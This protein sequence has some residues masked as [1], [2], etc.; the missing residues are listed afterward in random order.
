M[1][2]KIIGKLV[3]FNF[4]ETTPGLMLKYTLTSDFKNV[5]LT[6]SDF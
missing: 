5:V 3:M 2:M 4:S 6:N 1:V